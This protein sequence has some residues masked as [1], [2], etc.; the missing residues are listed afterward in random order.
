MIGLKR[1]TVKLIPYSPKWKDSFEKE[2]RRL[3]KSLGDFV[4]SIE[5]IGSTAVPGVSAKPIIDIAVVVKS[6]KSPDKLIKLLETLGYEYKQDNDVL[7]RLFFTKGPEKKRTHYIHVVE[8]KG[9][10]WKN[11]ILFRDYLLSHK[12]AVHQYTELKNKLAK[13]YALDR[14]SYT[15]GKDEFIKTI[16]MEAQNEKRN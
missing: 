4:I 10:E 6:I 1:G 3:Q 5:H 9:K 8:L 7:G 12:K 2:K 14:K 15:S 16:I 13:S 11:L